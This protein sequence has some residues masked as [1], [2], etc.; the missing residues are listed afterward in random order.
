MDCDAKLYLRAL[1]SLQAGHDPF[2]DGIASVLS[3]HDQPTAH[4]DARA[5]YPYAY[6]PFTLPLLRVIG[7][8]PARIFISGY[9]LFY[10]AGAIAPIWLAMGTTK[11]KE[12][13]YFAFLAPAAAFFPGLIQESTL[14]SGNIAYILYGSIFFTAYFGWRR[15]QW[16]W[17]YLATLAASCFKIPM[18][19]FLAIPLLSA[20]KQ[21]LPTGVTAAS[22]VGLFAVQ[23]WIWPSYFHNYLHVLN[24][25]FLYFRDFGVAPA[26]LVSRALL[27]QG[28]AFSAVGIVCFALFALPMFCMLF[29]LSRQFLAGKL[30]LEQWI[31]VML[32]GVMFLNPR[33]QEYDL[34]PLT[35]LMALVV[36]RT[37]RSFTSPI[38]AVVSCVLFFAAANISAVLIAPIDPGFFY[39]KCIQGT[40]LAGVFTSGC[41]NLVRQTREARQEEIALPEELL[42]LEAGD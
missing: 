6:S 27:D 4:L 5:P 41:W 19:V 13:R 3:Y 39:L 34:A 1:H 42:V 38:W 35:L 7:R 12:R 9:W 40:V 25:I 31:P 8:F 16:G 11:G 10:G 33:V 23:L 32:I 20:R 15:G 14:M 22:G 21:W 28:L 18:L 36:W 17:F 30:S 29:Y 37:L 26:G 24:L 2:A